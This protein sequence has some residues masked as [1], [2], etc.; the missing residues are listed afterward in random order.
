MSGEPYSET[1]AIIDL[2]KLDYERHRQADQRCLDAGGCPECLCV[3]AEQGRAHWGHCS[4]SEEV[5][6]DEETM[7][8]VFVDLDIRCGKPITR[9]AIEPYTPGRFKTECCED[10]WKS[11]MSGGYIDGG[12]INNSKEQS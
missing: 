8:S 5:E 10:C 3:E 4:K 11:F 9:I 2:G 6:F 1:Q 12:K 7:C